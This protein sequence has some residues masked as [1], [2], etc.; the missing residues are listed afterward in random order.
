MR[1]VCGRSPLP[2]GA[3]RRLAAGRNVLR[4]GVAEAAHAGECGHALGKGREPAIGAA[5]AAILRAPR[6]V[7]RLRGRADSGSH[8]ENRQ[9]EK[10]SSHS[11]LPVFAALRRDPPNDHEWLRA[12]G[13]GCAVGE[14][15]C[16]LAL[17]KP[18]LP[19]KAAWHC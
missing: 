1:L 4:I 7:L 17:Q 12:R 5:Q 14:M 15:Y 13:A 8:G 6:I 18:P 19:L 16:V 11:D 10:Q 9:Y 3:R 2:A